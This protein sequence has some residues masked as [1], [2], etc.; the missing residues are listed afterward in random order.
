MF[1]P[2]TIARRIAIWAFLVLLGSTAGARDSFGWDPTRLEPVWS[3][4]QSVFVFGGWT[5]STDVWSTALF[6]L[7][8]LDKPQKLY[9]NNI[10]GAA[11]QRDVVGF[12]RAI[13]GVELGL[14]DRFGHYKVCCIS[15][16]ESKSVVHSAEIWAGVTARLDQ[17]N[18]FDVVYLSPGV[19]FGVSTISSPIGQEGL[20]QLDKGSARTLLYLA[21]EAA[22]TLPSAPQIELVL[23]VHHRS[24]A[25]GTLG[26]LK[27]GNNANVLGFRY[28]F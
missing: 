12:G 26:G 21:L 23:R 10:V 18:L 20:H 2:S 8:K 14:A 28:R 19:V 24:G 1:E 5:S 25:Y 9:D 13:F 17:L 27:E 4:K 16:V 6:N 15:I 7:N 3:S 22:F 11:Y